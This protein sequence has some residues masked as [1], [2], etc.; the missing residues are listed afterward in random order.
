M[1]IM[2]VVTVPCDSLAVFLLLEYKLE[3][4]PD[5]FRLQPN[6]TFILEFN[7]YVDFITYYLG[8][9]DFLATPTVALLDLVRKYRLENDGQ[10]RLALFSAFLKDVACAVGKEVYFAESSG[11]AASNIIHRVDSKCEFDTTNID[12]YFRSI[13]SFGSNLLNNRLCEKGYRIRGSIS[14]VNAASW[15]YAS[16]CY[17]LAT[18]GQF[19][20]SYNIK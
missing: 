17:Y 9:Y 1:V 5:V 18:N 20:W 7:S 4:V 12:T 19:F 2:K 11:K 3:P 8:S 14:S 15:K 16:V 6:V 13:G 10:A